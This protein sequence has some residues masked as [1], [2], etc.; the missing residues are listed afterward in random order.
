MTLEYSG[1]NSYDKDQ[2]YKVAKVADRNP[3][4]NEK[5][6]VRYVG[7]D[8][9][10]NKIVGDLSSAL[11]FTNVGIETFKYV[12][13]PTLVTTNQ[14]F[15]YLVSWPVPSSTDYPNYRYT[16]IYESKTLQNFGVDDLS[17]P[18]VKL[19]DRASTNSYVVPTDDLDTRYVKIR[20]AGVS[21]SQT[22]YSP[23]SLA[24]TVKPTDPVGEA[25]DAIPPAN[26]TVESAVWVGNNISIF[27]TMPALDPSKRFIIRLTNGST[28]GFFYRF[29]SGTATQQ[30]IVLTDQELYDTLGARFTSF[31]GLLQGS[32]SADNINS[33]TAFT[34]A[35][36]SNPLL[37]VVPAFTLNAVSN[38]YTAT[39]VLPAGASYARVYERD[40][41]WGALTPT[42][43]EGVFTGQSPA[44]IKKTVY[45]TRYIK[46]QYLS[47]D[48]F[49]SSFSAEQ[50]VTPFDSIA[51]DTT[52]PAA[53]SQ[54]SLTASAGV[55][56]TGTL[57]FNGF[58]NLGWAAISDTTLRGYRIRF[59]PYK[60]S[61]PFE[62]YSYADSS[63]QG[64]SYRLS[65]LALGATY[66]IAIASYD[67]FNNTSSTYTSYPNQ[68]VSGTPALANYITSGAAGFQFGSG[69][70]DKDGSQNASAQGIYLSNSNYWYL[71][72]ANSAQFKIGGSASNFVS[73][74]GATL[75]VDGNL[76]V[77]GGTTIG[78]NI[79][80]GTSGASIYQGTLS[81]GNLSGDGFILNSGGL[82]I[83]KGVV[84]LRLDTSD[85]GIYA[86]YGQ[87]AGWTI[88]TSKFERGTTNTYTGISSSGTYA[89]YAGSPASAGSDDAKFWVKPDGSVK[90]TDITITGGAIS[91]G[92]NFSVQANTGTLKAT[93]A[94]IDGK[95]TASS[96][97]ITGDLQ[98][99]GTLYS[100]ADK[101]DGDRILFNSAGIAGYRESYASGQTPLFSFTPTTFKFGNDT[102]NVV[103]NADGSITMASGIVAN[104]SGEDTAVGA[105]TPSSKLEITPS[106]I[107]IQ[108]IPGLGNG[109]T[110][111]G[112]LE[113]NGDGTPDAYI[114]QY[115]SKGYTTSTNGPSYNYGAAARYRTIIADP[116]D[117]NK[118][119]R[120]FGVYYGS[121]TA[122]Q[123]APSASTG[124]VG[125][126]WL[127]W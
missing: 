37:G 49:T 8:E 126:I 96:G 101:A 10:G 45:T 85:G 57:G 120:G 113:L 116:Y 117:D 78:G 43:S 110:A 7:K 48:G 100:G 18:A 70:K 103:M 87:I 106:G 33:G 112:T 124:F 27:L 108:N 93:G 68:T 74:D 35:T 30:T 75:K 26:V 65:G 72:S 69:I 118:L 83:K 23:L 123:G 60:A 95:I 71:T 14:N 4:S 122:A 21:G 64:T 111:L 56:N 53:P 107:K 42:E 62:N 114:T 125:D 20:H 12:A 22:I 76:G 17:N 31:D 46:L 54:A 94:D 119:K 50:T 109:L 38:G 24:A 90:A 13:V 105:Y 63:G 121:R 28:V 29:A 32:D 59:R 86:Q 44:L 82:T 97:S 79:S 73:W 19:I 67:E 92:A 1:K 5:F 55:D 25:V 84:N 34:V 80:M 104:D 47:N 88:D 61:A 115:R 3:G 102:T 9:F 39:W 2:S 66:E 99:S 98:V 40:S 58:I 81:S 51:V 6:F 91:V 77:A 41:S 127:S 89:F 16:E 11:V 15:S 36:K 52:G